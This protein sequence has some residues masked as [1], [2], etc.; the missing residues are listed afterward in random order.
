MAILITVYP[1]ESQVLLIMADCRRLADGNS[2]QIRIYGQAEVW[3]RLPEDGMRELWQ[4]PEISR[5]QF[6]L[7]Y[8]KAK[9]YSALHG[10]V[11]SACPDRAVACTAYVDVTQIRQLRKD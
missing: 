6:S 3:W 11:L 9:S 10:I 1:F 7:I 4:N 5:P 2:S 8:R